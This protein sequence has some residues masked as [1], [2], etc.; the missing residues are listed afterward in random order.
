V[1]SAGPETAALERF[2]VTIR[3]ETREDLTR[4]RTLGF[5]LFGTTASAAGDDSVAI[6]GLLSLIQVGA[7][8]EDGFEV[9]VHEPA[10]RRA[11][12]HVQESTASA[13]VGHT[14]LTFG[15]RCIRILMFV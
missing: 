14:G 9:T 2:F 13:Y 12:A 10:S 15:P 1:Q 4:L 3:G 8:V 11:K 7:A 5:D 6:E